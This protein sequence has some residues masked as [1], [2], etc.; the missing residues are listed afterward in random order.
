MSE[1]SFIFFSNLRF[2]V[3]LGVTIKLQ[4]IDEERVIVLYKIACLKLLVNI[5]KCCYALM[6][7]TFYSYGTKDLTVKSFLAYFNPAD[8]DHYISCQQKLM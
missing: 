3:S 4:V 7:Y 6:P 5:V 8:Y 1:M 2:R